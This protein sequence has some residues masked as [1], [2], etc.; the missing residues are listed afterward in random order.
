MLCCVAQEHIKKW[1]MNLI[2][3]S[4]QK[5]FPFIEGLIVKLTDK[6][7]VQCNKEKYT[8]KV[9]FNRGKLNPLHVQH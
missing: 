3:R 2:L 4:K 7:V 9:K 6:D 1:R 5:D 8:L